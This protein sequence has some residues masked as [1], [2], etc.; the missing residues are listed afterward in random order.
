MTRSLLVL[1]CAVFTLSVFGQIK[2]DVSGYYQ[3][4]RTK[5]P[6][7][8]VPVQLVNQK[9]GKSYQAITDED[10][11]FLFKNVELLANTDT[12]VF[13]LSVSNKKYKQEIFTIKI[14]SDHTGEYKMD[15][16]NPFKTSTKVTWM[17]NWGDWNGKEN[18][19][20]HFTAKAVL[21][22][23]GFCCFNCPCPLHTQKAK[24]ASQRR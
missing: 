8:D 6:S 18:Y 17:F 11:K 24:N 23:Y 7:E 16:K 1:F 9:T 21:V 10:G 19:W 14:D 22:I 4:Y 13:E 3:D 2:R 12:T 5:G 15:R 20:S